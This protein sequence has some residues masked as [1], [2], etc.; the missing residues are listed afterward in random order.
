M[1]NS[2][3]YTG[4]VFHQRLAER[5]HYLN[6]S[7]FY[8]LIDLNELDAL[9]RVSKLFRADKFSW[10]SFHHADYGLLKNA[11]AS[12]NRAK[13]PLGEQ[14]V[15]L[16]EKN[17]IVQS[18]WHFQLLTMPRILGYV[19]NPISLVYCY[20]GQNT[21]RAMIYEVNNT[22]D[23]RIHYVLPVDDARPCFKH[24]CLKEMFVSP[25]FDMRGH[26]EFDVM[27]PAEQLKFTVDYYADADLSLRASFAGRRMAFDAGNLRKLAASKSTHALKVIAGIHWEAIKLWMKG[28]PI[29][30]H[31]ALVNQ[32][33]EP[34][35]GKYNSE[36]PRLA[37]TQNICPHQAD[38]AQ[39]SSTGNTKPI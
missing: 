28:L 26:Y 19:F 12:K 20:D 27:Y 11:K 35:V 32:D 24:R 2:A 34:S 10:F 8:F 23:E 16:L 22:F 13:T 21:L 31:V 7:T 6:Y 29:V 18:D 4:R 37:S 39:N 33:E 3:I 30:N 5:E 9:Q 25:F 15:S 38:A 1:F 36:K 14:Y 17:N